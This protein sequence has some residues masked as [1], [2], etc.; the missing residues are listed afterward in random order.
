MVEGK[1]AKA[2]VVE[3]PPAPPKVDD[4][5][6]AP[7][8]LTKADAEKMVTDAVTKAVAD[9]MAKLP[10]GDAADQVNLRAVARNG[11]VT[12]VDSLYG[13]IL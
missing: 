11:A 2:A 7:E 12:K 9:A 6:P 13:G 1:I 3:P 5:P 8:V 10:K 4:P